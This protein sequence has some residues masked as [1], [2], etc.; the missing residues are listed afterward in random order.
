M[1]E[2]WG[3][4]RQSPKF[5]PVRA[6]PL[7][8]MLAV[9]CAGCSMSK[10]G[11]VGIKELKAPDKPTVRTG[12]LG[13]TDVN[14]DLQSRGRI[15]GQSERLAEAG[16]PAAS[17]ISRRIA[18]DRSEWDAYRAGESERPRRAASDAAEQAS[19]EEKP[20]SA[21][22]HDMDLVVSPAV[23]RRHCAELVNLQLRIGLLESRMASATGPEKDEAAAKLEQAKAELRAVEIACAEETRETAKAEPS[24]DKAIVQP[25]VL[26]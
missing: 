15:A 5:M 19:A 14:R 4:L 7:I 1:V 2:S 16:S 6:L 23:R 10:P 26:K 24:A 22:K 13:A 9:L 12:R 17:E 8:G 25:A 21:G 18:E 20:P 3:L 11:W